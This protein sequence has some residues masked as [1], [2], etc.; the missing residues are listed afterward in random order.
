M[1]LHFEKVVAEVE[2]VEAPLLSQE[3]DDH[4]ARPVEAVSEA[5]PGGKRK[6]KRN[7]VNKRCGADKSGG[8]KSVSLLHS[9]H[10]ELVGSYWDAIHKLHGA[11]ET[12]EL[13]ALVDVHHSV[14]GERAAPDG[15]LEEAAHTCE[16]DLEHGQT[17][18]QP[19]FG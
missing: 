10:C 1:L 14:A 7:G 8:E 9:L 13:H 4:T 16:D 3:S 17:A 5:L 2:D 18:A 11:P 6:K 15:V 19:L 12:V